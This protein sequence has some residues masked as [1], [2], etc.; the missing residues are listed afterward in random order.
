MNLKEAFDQLLEEF[1]Y[2]NYINSQKLGNAYKETPEIVL[3]HLPIGSK[4]LDFGCG[5]LNF[6]N[7]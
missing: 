7:H 6:L 2:N 5:N 1:P 3:E 4:I